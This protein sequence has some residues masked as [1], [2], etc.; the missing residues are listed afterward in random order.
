MKVLNIFRPKRDGVR[1]FFYDIWLPLTVLTLTAIFTGLFF[2]LAG[3]AKIAD[4]DT[5]D[6]F[7]CNADGNVE[8]RTETEYNPLWDP[9]LFFTINLAYGRLPF[10]VVKF[11][12]A[13]WDLVVGRGGQMLAAALAYSH[14]RRSFALVLELDAIPIA[15]VTLL[16]CQ[17]VQIT[18]VWKLAQTV[19]LPK[20]WRRSLSLNRARLAAHIFVCS[21]VLAFAT[22]VSVMT[23][24]RTQL[25]GVFGYVEDNSSLLMPFKNVY[26]SQM[27]L[28]DGER[29][30]LSENPT[31]IPGMNLTY[32]EYLRDNF[33]S[34]I[35]RLHLF[36]EPYAALIDC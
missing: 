16:Y 23:G 32:D 27:V 22:L 20:L 29:V 5:V 10:S 24:Y 17:Q 18:S 8:K 11:I 33:T 21:Y 31:E 6:L 14:L 1:R 30:G 28:F 19:F 13:C 26:Q 7:F 12:D 36:S 3:P 4:D 15:T 2:D 34:Y 9:S 25:T 35:S